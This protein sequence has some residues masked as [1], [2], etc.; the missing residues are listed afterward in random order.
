MGTV[1]ELL[2]LAVIGEPCVELETPVPEVLLAFGAEET[3]ALGY[4]GG[5]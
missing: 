1:D 2:L 4:E 3:D 5:A